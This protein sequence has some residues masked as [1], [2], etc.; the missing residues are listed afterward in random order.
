M[1]KKHNKMAKIHVS[2]FKYRKTGNNEIPF[3]VLAL[4]R[5]ISGANLIFFIIII[6]YQI[7]FSSIYV[8]TNLIGFIEVGN[9]FSAKVFK[10][11]FQ[12]IYQFRNIL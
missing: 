2:K 7:W 9:L 12:Q 3:I 1:C 5:M 6:F 11:S 8:R 10:D 4:F